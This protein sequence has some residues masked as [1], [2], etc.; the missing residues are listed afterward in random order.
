MKQA[1]AHR[2]LEVVLDRLLY[3]ID[4]YIKWEK[5]LKTGNKNEF[6]GVILMDDQFHTL[7]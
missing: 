5:E 1:Y 7:S 2:K 6:H 4:I 3:I